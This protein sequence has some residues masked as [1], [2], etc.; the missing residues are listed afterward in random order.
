MIGE[1]G[2][3]LSGGQRQ[4][5]A[6]ARALRRRP[7]DP[8][9]RRRDLVGRRARPSSEI[10]TA[11]TEVMDGRTTFVIAHRLST[12]SLADTIVVLDDGRVLDHGT[13]DELMKRCE[14]L[15]RA[16]DQGHARERLPD[17]QGPDGR[18]EIGAG[19]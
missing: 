5:V 12:I 16:G 13:H 4:R 3:T 15:P 14:Q 11:L 17:A 9:S 19:L 6:I 7:A 8:D 1:R 18:P 10:K 2:I